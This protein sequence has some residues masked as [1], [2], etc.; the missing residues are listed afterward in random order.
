LRAVA[1]TLV[2]LYH[3]GVPGFS[4]GFLGVDIFFVISGYLMA[5]IY[6]NSTFKQ[7]YRA[8]AKRLAPGLLFITFTCIF[9]SAI[10]LTP[11][12]FKE[13]VREGI[14]GITGSSNFYFWSQDTYFAPERFRPLLHLWTLAV[15]IQ[16]YLIFPLLNRYSKRIRLLWPILAVASFMVSQLVLYKSPKTSFFLLPPRIWE[17][18]FGV[19][20]AGLTV[21]FSNLSNKTRSV[22]NV[23][24]AALILFGLIIPIDPNSTHGINGHPG[25]AAVL[26]TFGTSFL[27]V[28]KFS[29]LSHLVKTNSFIMKIGDASYLIY[30]IH[31]PLFVFMNYSPFRPSNSVLV[32]Y[33]LKIIG[34]T[35]AIFLGILIMRYLEKPILRRNFNLRK[36]ITIF[37][38]MTIASLA[39]VP[40]NFGKTEEL[41]RSISNSIE[42]RGPYRCG[43]LFRILNPTAKVC[44]LHTSKDLNAPNIMLLGNS[45]ADMVKQEFIYRASKSNYNLY[46]WADNNPFTG[47]DTS[48]RSIAEEIAR[49]NVTILVLHS[50]YLYPSVEEIKKLIN[51]TELEGVKIYMMESVPTFNDSVPVL[52]YLQRNAEKVHDNRNV[53]VESLYV[54]QTYS[55][56]KSSR[57]R[58][59]STHQYFC[60][61][62]CMWGNDEG[63]LFYF[64]SNHL[65]LLGARKLAPV[66]DSIISDSLQ[67]KTKVAR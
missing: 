15:E 22:A 60:T 32:G 18:A 45:H 61:P 44:P 6:A 64:D 29:T 25:M 62:V 35:S 65:T 56:I 40:I 47:S 34:I 33:E 9:I 13:L 42:D 67:E 12:Q 16:F 19:I 48:I 17:F 63:N 7:F 8:R 11:F 55:E 30:L 37:T 53:N 28:S 31:F 54:N 49:L 46:F 41:S 52:E 36:F 4:N 14:V 27:L 10:Y 66:V 21:K 26:V 24:S 2:L 38:A 39:L 20:A 50:S 5:S 58:Y 51:D 43:K 59:F 57:F 1:V 3:A 23:L